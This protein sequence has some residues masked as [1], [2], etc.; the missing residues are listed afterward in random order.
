MDELGQAV[1][2]TGKNMKMF[3]IITIILG[4]SEVPADSGVRGPFL[5]IGWHLFVCWVPIV[6]NRLAPFSTMGHFGEPFLIL[7]LMWYRQ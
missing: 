2:N 1:D 3:G 6:Q 7:V 5:R 4:V